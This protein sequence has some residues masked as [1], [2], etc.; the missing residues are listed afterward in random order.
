LGYELQNDRVHLIDNAN[1]KPQARGSHL[2]FIIKDIASNSLKELIVSFMLAGVTCFF[3][4]SSAIPTLLIATVGMIALNI[5]FRVVIQMVVDEIQQTNQNRSDRDYQILTFC[6]SYLQYVCPL[7]FS[8]LDLATR[9][10]LIHEFGHA[11]A[12]ALLYQNARPSIEVFPFVG[13]ITRFWITSLTNLGKFF[14]N[15]YSRLIVSAAGPATGI[16]VATIELGLAH[17]LKREHPRLHRYL[18]CSAILC[19]AQHVIYAL[20]TLWERNPMSGH[21]FANLWKIGG[22]HPLISAICLVA[23]PLIVQ[24]VLFKIDASKHK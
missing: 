15:K 13:G 5:L 6:Y 3:V 24:M 17:Y 21:D 23:L 4:A 7:N 18:L 14:G 10:V 11:L 9:H 22:L 2:S 12:A 16:F 1:L 20:S 8:I 19:I